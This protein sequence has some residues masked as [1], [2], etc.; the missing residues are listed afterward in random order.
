MEELS[1]LPLPHR[2]SNLSRSMQPLDFDADYYSTLDW[3]GIPEELRLDCLDCAHDAV[4]DGTDASDIKPFHLHT[5]DLD[6]FKS[7]IGMPNEYVRAGKAAG[8]GFEA[9]SPFDARLA[10]P[11][12]ELSTDERQ[13]IFL[14]AGA[15]LFGDS[16]TVAEYRRAIELRMAP[17][18]IAV[19]A[20]RRVILRPTGSLTLSGPPAVLVAGSITLQSGSVLTS[21]TV[22]RILSD[23]LVKTEFQ[24]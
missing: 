8:P 22:S 7:W 4:L 10:Q 5:S 14:A 3:Y 19:Y 15:Y 24:A 12:A 2:S 21:K 11:D 23:H 6:R 20:A 17:F 9:L 13:D 16:A 18:E 1:V